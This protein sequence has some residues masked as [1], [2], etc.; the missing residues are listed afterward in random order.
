MRR[1]INAAFDLK[2][3]REKRQLSQTAVAEI[4]CT[5]QASV[6]RWEACGTI[7]DVFRKVW[8]LHWR[9]E[10]MQKAQVPRKS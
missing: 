4:L 6:S 10:D 5:T 8:I 1:A 3:E 9:I 7:P 2:G